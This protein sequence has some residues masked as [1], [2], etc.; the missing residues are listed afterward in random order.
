MALDQRVVLVTGAGAGIG[1]A[2]ARGMAGAGARVACADI[3]ESAAQSTAQTIQADGGESLALAADV[4]DLQ[5]ID[6]MV[7]EVTEQMGPIDVLVNNAGVTIRKY[8]MDVS[9]EDW[10]RIHRVNAKGVFFCLQRVARDMIVRG[11]GSIVNIASISGRG[12]AGTSNAAYS[13]SK[14]AVISMTRTA[15]QQLGEHGININAVCPGVTR[16]PL[17]ERSMA[18]RAAAMNV[19][20]EE[21]ERRVVATVPIGR[22]NDPEDIAALAVFLASPAARNITGQAMNVDGGIITS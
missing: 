16:T 20:V 6:R 21:A 17:L 1:R 19:S 4:G 22:L 12:Y 7:G 10:D 15:A 13:A 14:G 11:G 2:I 3:D 5:Q 18:R 9:E 8:I